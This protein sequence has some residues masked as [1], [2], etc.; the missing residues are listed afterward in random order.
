MHQLFSAVPNALVVFIVTDAVLVFSTLVTLVA[1]YLTKIVRIRK[2]L[3][4]KMSTYRY[5]GSA[6][7]STPHSS[8]T[9]TV[10]TTATS[11]DQQRKLEL[12]NQLL[13]ERIKDLENQLRGKPLD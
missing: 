6:G 2:G 11:P 4:D 12:E 10:S 7:L 13:R 3:G 8:T 1:L 9:E 5:S